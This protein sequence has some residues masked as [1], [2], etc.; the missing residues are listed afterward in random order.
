MNKLKLYS[1]LS[2]A[3][4]VSMTSQAASTVFIDEINMYHYLTKSNN[5][6]VGKNSDYQFVLSSK[7]T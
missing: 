6:L 4:I 5:S 2:S 1:F 3:F 7:V